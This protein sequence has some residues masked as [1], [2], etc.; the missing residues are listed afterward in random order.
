[1]LSR[2]TVGRKSPPRRRAGDPDKEAPFPSR[3]TRWE[4][5]QNRHESATSDTNPPFCEKAS[6]IQAPGPLRADWLAIPGVRFAG[7]AHDGSKRTKQGTNDARIAGRAIRRAAPPAGKPSAM[8]R[9]PFR[10]TWLAIRRACF[11]GVARDGSRRTKR[12]TNGARIAG[13]AIR[14]AAAWAGKPLAASGA[15]VA[16][17]RCRFLNAVASAPSR[18]G[19]GRSKRGQ[20]RRESSTWRFAR[21]I[22]PSPPL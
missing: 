16:D 3:T 19:I 17:Y 7:L 15:P 11:R 2:R 8:F 14:H 21:G 5:K 6:R 1:M 13:P 20:R 12:G 4:R 10:R 22:N 9:P 18:S